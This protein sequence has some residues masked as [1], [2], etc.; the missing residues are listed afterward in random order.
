LVFFE[1][2]WRPLRRSWFTVGRVINSLSLVR[3][4]R[5]ARARYR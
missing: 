3:A 5:L 4:L 2:F 1:T